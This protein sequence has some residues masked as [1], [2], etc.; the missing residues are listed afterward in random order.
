MLLEYAEALTNPIKHIS[1]LHKR[2]TQLAVLLED[3]SE[4]GN[5]CGTQEPP[6][7]AGSQSYGCLS[8][9]SPTSPKTESPGK[10]ATWCPEASPPSTPPRSTR[11]T[12]PLI[13]S[14][15]L[16]QVEPSCC[17]SSQERT[18]ATASCLVTRLIVIPSSRFSSSLENV[19]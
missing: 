10:R 5:S 3:N 16:H 4:V 17:P 9:T 15:C 19:L 8:S 14:S 11:W 7:S 12:T 13:S 6:L 18:V 2:E 1:Q